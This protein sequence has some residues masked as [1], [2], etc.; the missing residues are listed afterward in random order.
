MP[1]TYALDEHFET[2]VQTQLASGR[3]TDASDVLRD[4]LRLMEDRERKLGAL[5]ASIEQGLV[6]IAAAH[7]RDLGEICDE[8]VAEITARPNPQPA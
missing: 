5:D 8:L 7:V 3:Y 2:F 6:D 1:T 4:A